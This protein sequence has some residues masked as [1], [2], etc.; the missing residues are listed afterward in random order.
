MHK[1]RFELAL[2]V[3]AHVPTEKLSLDIWRI[4][5]INSGTIACA[6]GW[7][8]FDS[9]FEALGLTD[10]V[11]GEPYCDG[12]FGF[13]ALAKFFDISGSLARAVFGARCEQPLSAASFQRAY[14][15]DKSLW[16]A[17][18]NLLLDDPEQFRCIYSIE[19]IS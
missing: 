19:A 3:I 6:A 4:T 10:Y 12:C 14:T 8:T 5:S 2:Q 18:V 11:G 13:D 15:T 7:I 17:R 1:E 9:R 16:E